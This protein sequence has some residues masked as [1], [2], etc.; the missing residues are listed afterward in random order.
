MSG[1]RD[2]SKGYAIF[3][4]FG[5]LKPDDKIQKFSK[6]TDLCPV[7]IVCCP[8]WD[9][10]SASFLYIALDLQTARID[11]LKCNKNEIGASKGL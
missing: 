8:K 5:R 4:S 9:F 2:I 1:L 6:V 10:S 3:L 7:L 11:T